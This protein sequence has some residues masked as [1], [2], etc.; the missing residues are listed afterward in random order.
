MKIFIDC[1]PC[2]IRQSI[3]AA[4]MASGDPRVHESVLK[5][6]LEQIRELD[7]SKTPPHMGREIHRTVRKESG[8]KDPYLE[9]K[10]HFNS[11]AMSL[12]PELKRRVRASG[13]GIETAARLAI[14]GNIIDFNLKNGCD[15]GKL[16]D[17]IEETLEKDLKINHL[18][19]FVKAVDKAS[20]IFYICDN[21]GEIVFDRVLIEELPREKV[22]VGVRG[23]PVLNDATM[24]DAVFCGLT[25]TV[26]VID[27]GT[28]VPG[29]ILDEC[30]DVFRE[31]FH[32]ADVIVSKGQGNYE[33][34][35]QADGN[36]FFI[37][38]AKCPIA[39]R[40]IGC[41]IGDTILLSSIVKKN[42]ENLTTPRASA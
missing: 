28:D 32:A 18:N 39:A 42:S 33:T 38:K 21:A 13:D 31:T 25:E 30:S 14:A 22:T 27:N 26:N 1:I 24:E 20:T 6:V 7:Y 5:S 12:Y 2:F 15:D 3:D 19:E 11:L 16:F 37:L 35:N 36:I 9:V 23:Y 29:T 8:N 40:D 10:R 34:L 41:D 4:R 17:T